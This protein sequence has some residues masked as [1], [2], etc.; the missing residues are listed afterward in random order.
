MT[1]LGTL[2]MALAQAARLLS[3]NPPLAAQQA[4]EILKLL[5]DQPQ[6]RLLLAT[7]LRLQ[8]D[9]DGAVA[10]LEPL[11]A[12]QP[13]V[14]PAHYELGLAF[15]AL[16]RRAE[17][18]AALRR[19]LSLEPRR[20]E[21]WRVLGDALEEAGE[22]V[23][24]GH[25][26]AHQAS[27]SEPALRQAWAALRDGRVAEAERV[28][29]AFLERRPRD[30]VAL[31]T[32]AECCMRLERHDEAERLLAQCLEL[33]PDFDAARYVYAFALFFL[34]Q[35]PEALDQINRLLAR[36]ATNPTYRLLQANLLTLIGDYE[37]SIAC[38]ASL[39]ADYP[40]QATEWQSYGHV[41][42]TVGRRDEAIAAYRRSIEIDP[43]LSL[44]Y[45]S[46]ANLKTY[47]FSAA[48]IAA[49]EARLARADIV[50]EDRA[51]L[52]FAL[53]KAL[54][55]RRSYA[56]SFAHYAKGA[57]LR[58]AAI[59]YDAAST[60]AHLEGSRTLFTPAFFA[61]R[62]GAGCAAPDPI[63]VVGMPRAGSTLI[64]QILASHSAVEGTSEL[65]DL[66]VIARRLA[67]REGKDYL[68]AVRRLDQAEL[69]A[70]GEE[71]L[72]RTRTHRKLGRPLFIDKT[73][74][75]FGHV[76]LIHLIL[77][78]AK[79]IDARRDPMGCC[80]SVFKQYFARGQHFSYDLTELGRFY[81]DYV[82]LM[83]HFDRALPGRVHRVLYERVVADPEAEIR[84]L[85]A[86]CGLPFED[87][88]LRFYENTRPVRTPSAEQVR[89]PI[90][91]DAVDQWRNYEPWLGPLKAALGLSDTGTTGQDA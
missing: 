36:D 9:H 26:Y 8:R 91:S 80:F 50:D 81:V 87:A 33:A 74:N 69:R 59:A 73:P 47:R 15:H 12:A 51:P 34:T 43:G 4:R 24:A 57:A 6:A 14:A 72:A 65:P 71:F 85:L 40:N 39:L 64:E 2:E 19:A 29:R 70:L 38:F 16:G 30:G 49:M 79:I 46:L 32:I 18:I 11:A 55:D 45:W 66:G 84:A 76:G 20:A 53:G 58:R 7:A 37:R 41:L 88:C 27:V 31:W 86:F 67:G 35:A 61:E 1:A 25:A 60:T 82:A 77:P 21:A 68:A 75:N 52:H 89:Q 5:P 3:S 17:A 90:F 78:N 22:P 83:N 42:S 48:E 23:A 44:A 56:L 63:F 28:A 54:E 13:T 10:L 62:S